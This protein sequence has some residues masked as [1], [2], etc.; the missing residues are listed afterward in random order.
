MAMAAETAATALPIID[1]CLAV[2]PNTTANPTSPA[3]VLG[4]LARFSAQYTTE[5][6]VISCSD[7]RPAAARSSG[8]VDGQVQATRVAIYLGVVARGLAGTD[9]VYCRIEF[10][11][12]FLWCLA[13]TSGKAHLVRRRTGQFRT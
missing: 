2:T 6:I 13:K 10:D 8:T 7:R 4:S 11:S 5:F 9:E 12:K 1:H 3:Q